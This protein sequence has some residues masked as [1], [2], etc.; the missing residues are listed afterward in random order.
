MDLSHPNLHVRDIPR[1][2]HFYERYFGFANETVREE[3]LLIVRNANGFDLAL[4]EDSEPSPMRKWFHI[5]VRLPSR[6][7]VREL[8]DRMAAETVS[9]PRPAED[10]VSWMSFRCA[11]PDWPRDRDLQRVRSRAVGSDGF[12]PLEAGELTPRAWT[13]GRASRTAS[14]P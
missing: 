10:Y 11:D 4:M 9:I 2:R 13:P 14:P 1:A 5:G 3:G 12:D 7:A 6:A 8:H